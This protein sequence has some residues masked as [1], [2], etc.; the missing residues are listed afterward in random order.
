LNPLERNLMRILAIGTI[1]TTALLLFST[2]ASALNTDFGIDTYMS[3]PKVQ[4]TAVT[5]GLTTVDFNSVSAGACPASIAIGAISGDCTVATVASYGGASTNANDA[6]P[7][8]TGAGSNFA[9]TASDGGTPPAYEFT[10]AL[11][12]PAKYLGLWWSAGSPGNTIELY[13]EGELVASMTVDAILDLL[14]G[15]TVTTVGGPTVNTV[16]YEGNP[17]NTA[18]SPGEP[19]LYLNLYAT[20]GATFDT[21]SF[22]GGGF[23]L[24]NIA[25]SD[26]PQ[27]PGS[28][29]IAVEFIA[30]ENAPPPALANT[31]FN[32]QG[33]LGLGLIAVA[34]GAVALRRRSA[35]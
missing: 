10:I 5:T 15:V 9:S 27:V 26:L 24:D 12:E 34:A 31:G 22:I 18:L 20:G 32:A 33:L 35:L 11:T 16:D 19:F 8:T 23:E 28:T 7:T 29:E 17:R 14:D 25:V 21:I 4:G 30:G 6:T 3:S 1:T 2:P 13:S